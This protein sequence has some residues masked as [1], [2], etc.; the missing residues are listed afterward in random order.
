MRSCSNPLLE[1]AFEV[2]SDGPGNLLRPRNPRG[3][4]ITGHGPLQSEWPQKQWVRAAPKG[5]AEAVDTA[6]SLEGCME[7]G[8]LGLK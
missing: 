5:G 4:V 6:I 3:G 7:E 2:P 1:A 8:T